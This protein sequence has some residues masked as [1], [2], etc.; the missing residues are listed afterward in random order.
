MRGAGRHPVHKW[1]N[2]DDE[3]LGAPE[4]DVA[5]RLTSSGRWVGPRSWGLSKLIDE[6]KPVVEDLRRPGL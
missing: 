2:A 1:R 3:Y 5:A 6:E 4:G